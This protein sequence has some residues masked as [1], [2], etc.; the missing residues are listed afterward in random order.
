MVQATQ[1]DIA[2]LCGQNILLWVQYLELVTLRPKI[3]HQLS[4]E[5]HNLRVSI[6]RV[7]FQQTNHNLSIVLYLGNMLYGEVQL[8]N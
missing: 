4:K 8:Y 6:M 1:S 7:E 3:T 2:T 5:H